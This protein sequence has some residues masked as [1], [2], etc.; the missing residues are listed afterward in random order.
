MHDPVSKNL[1]YAD[2]DGSLFVLQSNGNLLPVE[3]SIAI[4]A[5]HG[6][7]FLQGIVIVDSLIV[8]V[9]I[10]S[11]GSQNRGRIMKDRLRPNGMRQWTVLLETDLYPASGTAYDHSFSGVCFSC[12]RDSIYVNSRSRTDHGEI[13][14]NGGQFPS[15]R[16]TPLTARIFRFPLAGEN[17]SLANDEQAIQQSGFCFA[18]VSATLSIWHLIAKPTGETPS[19]TYPARTNNTRVCCDK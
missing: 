8:L 7:T 13:Q 17:L 3:A 1:I 12:N 11:E 4:V 10:R 16:E 5:Q 18:M 9:G 2:V 19:P 15:L 6:I 14:A